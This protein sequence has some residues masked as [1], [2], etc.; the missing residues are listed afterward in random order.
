[1]ELTHFFG[2]YLTYLQHYLN[3]LNYSEYVEGSTR[4]KLTQ[5]D[6]RS[7]KVLLPPLAEQQ[8]IVNKIEELFVTLETIEK[9]L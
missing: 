7:I 5:A 3:Q 2:H 1:M 6:M 4:L 9:S 8:H